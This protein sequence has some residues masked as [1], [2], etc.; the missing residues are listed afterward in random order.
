[1]LDN[2]KLKSYNIIMFQTI[3]NFSNRWFPLLS[4]II[5]YLIIST[6]YQKTQKKLIND[7]EQTHNNIYLL[8]TIILFMVAVLF[9]FN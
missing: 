9:K 7:Y 8:I 4:I 1:M 3:K 2:I 6:T 5:V